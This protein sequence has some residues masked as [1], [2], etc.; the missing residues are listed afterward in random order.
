M[1]KPRP[2]AS[3]AVIG[4]NIRACRLALR[5]SQRA[6]GKA[7]G[8]TFQQVQKYEKGTNRVGSGRLVLVAQ[9]LQV[10]VAALFG[11]VPDAAR[12]GEAVN[13]LDARRLRLQFARALALIHDADVCRCLML[14]TESLARFTERGRALR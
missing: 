1:S 6:L 4:R 13:G 2:D 3:D 10:P 5:M 14:L 9:A 8:I 11:G 7:I 12:N